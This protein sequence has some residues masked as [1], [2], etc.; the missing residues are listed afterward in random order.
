MRNYRYILL[1]ATLFLC[2]CFL[3]EASAATVT[4]KNYLRL[5]QN[6]VSDDNDLKI[7]TIGGLALL[8]SNTG[9]VDLSYIESQIN[10]DSLA[11]DFGGGYVFNWDVSLYLSFGISLGYN[12]DT[13]NYNVAY[14]PEAGVV[15]ELTQK[16]GLSL[17]TKRY[18]RLYQ[19]NE[20]IIMMGLVFRE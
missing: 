1:L 7:T 16:I 8:K 20:P 12:L 3:S 5:E 9:F 10:G 14:Y 19:Q 15:V 6:Q 11:L 4:E 2:F 17:S 13:E 18:H